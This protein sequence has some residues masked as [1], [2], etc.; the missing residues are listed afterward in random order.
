MP[1][2]FRVLNIYE[3]YPI[4]GAYPIGAYPIDGSSIGYEKYPIDEPYEKYPIHILLICHVFYV[5]TPRN[6]IIAKL[7]I[8]KLGSSSVPIIMRLI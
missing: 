2:L 7:S 6:F 8:R 5:E 3:K 1:N 4:D